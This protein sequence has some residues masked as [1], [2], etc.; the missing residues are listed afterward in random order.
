MLDL[1]LNLGTKSCTDMWVA[2]SDNFGDTNHAVHNPST[3]ALFEKSLNGNFDLVLQL[4]RRLDRPET[5][6]GMTP[7][8]SRCT[9]G[10][11]TRV[12]G[13]YAQDYFRCDWRF[14]VSRLLSVTPSRFRP[15]SSAAS[16]V[17]LKGSLQ[18]NLP[19][20]AEESLRIDF[21]AHTPREHAVYLGGDLTIDSLRTIVTAMAN[22]QELNLTGGMV[23]DG[24]LLPDPDEPDINGKLLP[25][26]RRLHLEDLCEAIGTPCY[27]TSPIKLLA[28]RRFHSLSLGDVIAFVR[29][30]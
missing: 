5:M 17:Q 26:L 13:L 30:C 1:P 22:I 3:V 7:A 23:V 28:V 20:C 6:N 19:P 24:F 9:A 12:L 27:P 29:M 4:L 25:S 16:K 10:E 18:E 2:L 14:R 8:A 15:A 11:V 21:V